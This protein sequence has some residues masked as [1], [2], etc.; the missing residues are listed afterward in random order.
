MIARAIIAV[1]GGLF[2]AGLVAA[3]LMDAGPLAANPASD[4]VSASAGR[5][6]R[7]ALAALRR[8]DA[9][10]ARAAAE[11]SLARAPLN[12]RAMRALLAA[13]SALAANGA[14]LGYAAALG[15]RDTPLQLTLIRGAA[16]MGS[17]EEVVLRA[18]ALARRKQQPAVAYAALRAVSLVPEGRKLLIERLPT[19]P[20]RLAF[21]QDNAKLSAD[22][23]TAREALFGDMVAAG[24]RPTTAEVGSYVDRLMQLGQTPR[25]RA[26]WM[27]LFDPSGRSRSGGVYDTHF[28]RFGR[29]EGPFAWQVLPLIGASASANDTVSVG[30]RVLS[31]ETDG[32]ASGPL[33]RQVLVLP[34]GS[35]R[36]VTV[37]QQEGQGGD[38][39][40]GWS[41]TCAGQ[42]NALAFEPA[43][44][45]E[46]GGATRK[47]WAFTVPAGC[48]A[49][50]LDLFAQTFDPR[51]Q[52]RRTI[53]S[54][55]VR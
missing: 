1:A 51:R 33:V 36:L 30:N 5:L 3:S 50:Q 12:A 52:V 44:T 32:S 7:Y 38:D 8:K 13:D 46:V 34:A 31:V 19:A 2:G 45:A 17:A 41:I 6:D 22:D 21:F 48:N 55:E 4:P 18:D 42:P 39:G 23:L 53:F 16:E 20:W 49:Q 37:E 54:V 43:S 47:S 10:A 27:R 28:E 24:V 14:V 35:Y 9:A 15:W 11:R 25:A 29:A 26:V 40:F